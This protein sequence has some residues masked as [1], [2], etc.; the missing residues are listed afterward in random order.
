MG[1]SGIAK[2]DLLLPDLLEQAVSQ[3]PDAPMRRWMDGPPVSFAEVMAR[4]SSVACGLAEL[5]V[6]QEDTVLFMLPNGLEIII[7]W[8]AATL[9]GAVEVPVN[10]HDRGS[11][12]AHVIKDSRASVMIC[13]SSYLGYLAAVA[14]ACEGLR[15]IVTTGQGEPAPAG[16]GCNQVSFASLE[17]SDGHFSRPVLRAGDLMAVLYTSGTTGPA[18]GIMISYGQAAM[19]AGN[20]FNVLEVS[21]QDSF[22]ICMPLFHSNAQIIQVMPALMAGT[23]ASVWPQFDAVRWLD[24]VRSVG[25][26]ITNTLGIMCEAIY[27]Q[28]VR[29]DD[30]SNPVRLLQTIPAPPAIVRQFEKR[31]ALKCV[32]GYGLTD[33]GVISYRRPADPVVPG[34]SGRPLDEFEVII[35][36]PDTDEALPAGEVGEIMIRPRRSFGMMSGYW[37]NAE[38]TVRASRNL[39]FH[40]GD[41]GYLDQ[42][43]LLY[44]HDRLKDIIR[45]RGEN[46]SSAQ[47]EA[48]FLDDRRIAECAAVA[49]PAASGDDDV[50]VCLVLAPG[51]RLEPAELIR[52]CTGKMPYF[53]VPRY[54]T[55]LDGLPKTP[56]GKILK[57]QLR[58][59]AAVTQAWDRRAA[60]VSIGR[61]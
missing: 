31:F 38:A 16:P 53:A 2:K 15:T 56:T 7:A 24:Q 10:I 33:V 39:W 50:H 36:D 46:V 27:A 12:L 1:L 20:Y 14:P 23:V 9:L 6:R 18:K 58:D 60:G 4:A 57:R 49:A 30:Q 28:P 55:F 29:P 21:E 26:T 40:T 34:S 22:Y 37:R 32:D 8:L 41:A 51:E 42:A 35:G 43:G 45:V 61:D 19:N 59:S 44:F 3:R 25:A 52:M 48:V 5:G 13:D 17:A 47:V 11:F 54:I